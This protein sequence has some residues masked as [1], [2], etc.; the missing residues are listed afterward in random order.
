MSNLRSITAL[1]EVVGLAVLVGCAGFALVSAPAPLQGQC[2]VVP[3][4]AWCECILE[5]DGSVRECKCYDCT[6]ACETQ[7]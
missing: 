3:K 5:A 7:Q 2:K 1:K 6:L 4:C